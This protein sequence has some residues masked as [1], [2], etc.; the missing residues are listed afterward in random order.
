M[1]PFII[2]D[3]IDSEQTTIRTMKRKVFSLFMLCACFTL[4]KAQEISKSFAGVKKIELTA[5]SGNVIIAPG[6]SDDVTVTLV[7]T[8]DEGFHPVMKQQGSTLVLK[9]EFDRGSH[10]GHSTWTL[11]VPDDLDIR[12]NSGSGNFEA[13]KVS[14]SLNMNSGSGNVDLNDVRGEIRLNTGSGNLDVNA[15]D[16]TLHSNTGSGNINVEGSRGEIGL[17]AGSG[18]IEL[19]GV[20]GELQANVG[21]GRI[22]AEKIVLAGPASFNSGSGNVTVELAESPGYDI[23]LNSGSGNATLNLNGNKI[24]G[25]IVMT[26]NKRTGKIEA[27]F[28]FD[29]TEE[30]GDGQNTRI[31]KTAKLGS[32]DVEVKIGTGSGTAGVRE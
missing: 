14:M 9:E 28:A 21:S 12:S 11:T 20:N 3:V 7:H 8:Y 19:N 15:F 26:A 31:K 17:N 24:D 10:D 25:T 16:G 32:G 1:Q 30:I 13:S 2:D 4:V 5:A 27:P 23:S 18:S 29:T 6:T 22:D